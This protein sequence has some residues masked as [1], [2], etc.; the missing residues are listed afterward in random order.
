MARN[1]SPITSLNGAILTT[2]PV[3]V[4][5]FGDTVGSFTMQVVGSGTITAGAITVYASLDGVT[6]VPMTAA[7]T[8][9]TTAGISMASGVVTFTAAGAGFMASSPNA[10]PAVR[11]AKAAVTTN[12][13]GGGSVTVKFLGH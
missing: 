3:I 6:F 13:V 4:A 7:A 11:Y 1:R 5:D 9:G 10:G 12:F 8:T 2:D